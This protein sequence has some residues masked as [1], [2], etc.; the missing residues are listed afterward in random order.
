MA[1]VEHTLFGVVD[2]AQIA[3]ENLK[4]YEPPEG[5][6][7]AFSGGKDSIVIYDLAM[8]SGVKF[9]PN[10][11]M[12]T[13]D[14]PELVKFIRKNYPQVKCN[15]PEMTMWELIVE[16]KLPPTRVMRYC[17]RVLKEDSGN[18]NDRFVI[19]GVRRAESAARN[20]RWTSTVQL[21]RRV[22]GKKYLM[23]ILDWT[24]EEVWD[25]IRSNNISYCSLY[26]EGYKRLGCVMCPLAGPEKMKKDAERWPKIADAYKRAIERSWYKHKL[27]ERGSRWKEFDDLWRWWFENN[28]KTDDDDQGELFG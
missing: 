3:I 12:T 22:P 27:W 4:M 8:K 1:L 5:Y 2:K 21:C 15:R 18:S 13:V 14:P 11:N 26:D 9:D 10:Y 6:F 17:C 19:T 28:Q 23:P 7:L 20:R 24:D 16:R 25:Y